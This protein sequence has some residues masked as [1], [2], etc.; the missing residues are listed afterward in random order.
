[1]QKYFDH[2]KKRKTTQSGNGGDNT[3][4]FTLNSSPPGWVST[5]GGRG[6]RGEAGRRWMWRGGVGGR[7]HLA[8]SAVKA[9]SRCT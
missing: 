6:E 3:P 4:V 5:K 8:K 7:D 1:M 9:S 2:Y